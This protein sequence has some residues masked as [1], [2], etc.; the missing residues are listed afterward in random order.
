M[1]HA[2]YIQCCFIPLF[3]LSM[4][5]LYSLDLMRMGPL[6]AF[7]DDSAIVSCISRGDSTGYRK[8]IESFVLWCGA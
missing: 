5:T 7:P 1:L 8:I 3:A 4:D 2:L 6:Q